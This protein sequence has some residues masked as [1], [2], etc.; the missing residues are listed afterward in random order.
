MYTCSMHYFFFLSQEFSLDPVIPIYSAKPD[1]VKKAL[2]YVHSAALDKL[3]GKEL[4]L[5][6]AILPDNNGS[7]YGM[8]LSHSN[9]ILRDSSASLIH[10]QLYLFHYIGKWE[11]FFLHIFSCFFFLFLRTNPLLLMFIRKYTTK[12]MF[13]RKYVLNIL[14]STFH[15]TFSVEDYSIFHACTE[16]TNSSFR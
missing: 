10:F 8:I 14:L 9:I 6:I 11:C 2:K 13:T 1:L 7:L 3:G 5:L 4:E 12:K 15:L 16:E